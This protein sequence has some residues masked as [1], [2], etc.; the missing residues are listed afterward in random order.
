MTAACFPGGKESL[1]G[2]THSDRKMRR[3]M[4]ET[5]VDR[6]NLEVSSLAITPKDIQP[7]TSR[8]PK[9]PESAQV[10]AGGPRGCTVSQGQPELAGHLTEL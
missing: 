6:E 2:L 7:W 10:R 4:Y 3:G 1:E 8:T 9:L 5:D